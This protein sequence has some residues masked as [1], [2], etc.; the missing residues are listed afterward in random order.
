VSSPA[1]DRA[2]SGIPQLPPGFRFGTATSAYQVEGAVCE[3]GRGPSIWDT[4]CAQ[5]GRI[6]DGSSGAVA[7]DHYHRVDEDVAL[8]ARLGTTDHRFS[9]SWPRVQPDGRGAFNPA[10]IAFYDRLVDRLL[11]A[12]QQPVATL[13]HW[14]LPQGLEDDGGWLNRE[15]VERFAEYADHV[16]AALADRVA[17]WVPVNEPNV[18]ALRG[19]ATGTHAPGRTLLFDA[20]PATHHLLLAHGRAAIELRRHGATSVGC[21]NHHSPIWPA[22]D[23]DADVGASK[24]FD[25]L[26]NAMYL[27]PMLLGRYPRDLAPLLE[28]DVRDGDLATI[29]QPLD[30]YG[31]SYYMPLRVAAAREESDVPFEYS[32]V[33]GY[34][35]TDLGWPVVPDAL[36]E[37]LIMFR[38]RYRAALP[39]IVITESGCAYDTGPDA[40]GVVDDQARIDYLQGHLRAVQEAI[41][42]GVDVRGYYCSSLLDGFAWTEGLRARFGLVHVDFETLRRTPKRSFQWYA[43][44]IAAQQRD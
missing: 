39:P 21:A 8:L 30:F 9:I 36:R 24:L 5:P 15:T 34:P 22:S 41:A 16:G 10:G 18:A 29:R 3:D 26:W 27:E 11:E 43:D 40:D 7:C 33:L 32:E 2:R 20:L 4:F 38:A 28:E 17:H 1:A 14:D 13:Y 19:Y 25:A 42:R 23:D 31:V 6:A 44:L 12:G 35:T 37:W